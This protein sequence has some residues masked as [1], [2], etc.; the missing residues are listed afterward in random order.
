MGNKPVVNKE[1]VNKRTPEQRRKLFKVMMA[2]CSTLPTQDFTT[3]HD[4][5][6]KKVKPRK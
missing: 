6:C 4:V 3:V 1:G 5:K 2:I